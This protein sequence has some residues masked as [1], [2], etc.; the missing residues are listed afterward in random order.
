LAQFGIESSV[1]WECRV[2]RHWVLGSG[3]GAWGDFSG[4]MQEPSVGGAWC[5][6][7]MAT[8]SGAGGSAQTITDCGAHSRGSS[9]CS[10]GCCVSATTIWGACCCNGMTAGSGA[11]G[12][13]RRMTRCGGQSRCGSWYGLGCCGASAYGREGGAF[14]AVNVPSSIS[15]RNRTLACSSSRR[16]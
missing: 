15:C 12:G 9:G 6:K 13:V 11:G 5:F 10:F 2:G 1:D 3:S 4:A 16:T 14:G 7:G 8:G